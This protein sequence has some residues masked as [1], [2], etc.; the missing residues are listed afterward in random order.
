MFCFFG[1]VIAGNCRVRNHLC[2]HIVNEK[3][4][5]NEEEEENLKR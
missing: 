1:N 2:I 5:E 4:D 3:H